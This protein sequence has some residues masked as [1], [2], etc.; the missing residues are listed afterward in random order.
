MYEQVSV[1]FLEI[2][3]HRV[4][5]VGSLGDQLGGDDAL[6]LKRCE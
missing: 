3:E 4:E 6:V 1:V 5:L 2:S